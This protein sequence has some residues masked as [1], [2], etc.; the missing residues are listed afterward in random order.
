MKF[1]KLFLNLRKELNLTH[2]QMSKR[3][4]ISQGKLSK[5]EKGQCKPSAMDFIRAYQMTPKAWKSLGAFD[6][7]LGF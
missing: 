5:I 2:V 4:K 1:P 3:L 6:K 7:V